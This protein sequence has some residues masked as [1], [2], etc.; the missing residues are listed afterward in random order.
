MAAQ[1][2]SVIC[3]PGETLRF[4]RFQNGFLLLVIPAKE[5]EA[6]DELFHPAMSMRFR[7]SLDAQGRFI[8][9]GCECA[10]VDVT[11]DVS[12]P[13]GESIGA[14]V[15]FDRCDPALLQAFFR[16][17]SGE[18]AARIQVGKPASTGKS[19]TAKKLAHAAAWRPFLFNPLQA[20]P[21]AER[22]D[23][24]RRRERKKPASKAGSPSRR[25]SDRSNAGSKRRS[26]ARGR[27]ASR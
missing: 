2:L 1:T 27:G 19:R 17:L 10:G 18:Q 15:S 25:L 8:A 7:A 11:A 24:S 22:A 16:L 20:K 23:H 9:G 13:G 3:Q 21:S 4:T 5:S 14:H 26:G 12:T 6:I